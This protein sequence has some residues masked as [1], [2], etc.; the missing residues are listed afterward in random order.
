MK[1]R[2]MQYVEHTAHAT[3]TLTL[4]AAAFTRIPQSQ[5]M[6]EVLH[7]AQVARLVGN[8]CKRS[9]KTRGGVK[10]FSL[11]KPKEFFKKV[12]RI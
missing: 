3:L 12:I 8:F 6:Q 7:S 10:F 2:A 9:A 5:P 4:K 11:H 1:G